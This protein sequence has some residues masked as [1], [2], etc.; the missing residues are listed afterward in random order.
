MSNLCICLCI[1]SC[2]G[3]LWFCPKKKNPTAFIISLNGL[4]K[5]KV[6]HIPMARDVQ[7]HRFAAQQYYNF[8]ILELTLDT[9]H[10]HQSSIG[11][12]FTAGFDDSEKK[13]LL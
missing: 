7:I 9:L 11:S 13:I 3:N 4:A 6:V 10:S 5:N 8:R 12:V 1:A 2:I